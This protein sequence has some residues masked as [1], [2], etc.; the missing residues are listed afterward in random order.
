MED[1]FY[2]I[3]DLACPLCLLTLIVENRKAQPDSVKLVHPLTECE[4]S[5]RE[6][7]YPCEAL[8]VI[9]EEFR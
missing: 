7:Y 9:P 5:G 1:R 4:R 3:S 8:S 6:Y 2:R